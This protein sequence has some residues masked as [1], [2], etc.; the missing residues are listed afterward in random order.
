MNTGSERAAVS[1]IRHHHGSIHRSVGMLFAF[2]DDPESARDTADIL[3][4]MNL[5]VAQIGC[6]LVIVG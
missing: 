3:R 1:A 6:Q 4:A 5:E 2:F